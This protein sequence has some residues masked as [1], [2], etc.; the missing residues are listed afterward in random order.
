MQRTVDFYYKT[1]GILVVLTTWG[2][3]FL[4][5]KW[6]NGNEIKNRNSW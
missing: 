6:E 3:F 1:C 4:N 2:C 5:E